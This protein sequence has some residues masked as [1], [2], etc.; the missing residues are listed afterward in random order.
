MI[1]KEPIEWLIPGLI[2]KGELSSIA[3]PGG[4]GKSTVIQDFVCKLTNGARFNGSSLEQG[5]VLI[6]SFEDSPSKVMR[7]RLERAGAKIN[8]IHIP[9]D[10]ESLDAICN[11]DKIGSLI[12]RIM[13]VW[14]IIDPIVA[15]KPESTDI[16]KAGDVRKNLKALNI[17][18]RDYDIAITF[19]AHFNKAAH[20]KAANRVSGSVDMTSAVKS[21]LQVY[22]SPNNP[23]HRILV[24]SKSNFTKEMDHGLCYEITDNGIVWHGKAPYTADELSTIEA[25]ADRQDQKVEGILYTIKALKNGPIKSKEFFA[26]AEKENLKKRTMEKVKSLLTKSQRINI[27][28]GKAGEGYNL[29]HLKDHFIPTELRSRIRGNNE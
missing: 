7:P 27:E 1:P 17:L 12:K 22:K 24:Q 8:K 23:D 18:A 16:N 14:I 10:L 4:I 2:P 19:V 20:T 13:P 3:G 26:N 5:E 21:Q 29:I 25:Q 9:K 15:Y 11:N 6:L 28:G